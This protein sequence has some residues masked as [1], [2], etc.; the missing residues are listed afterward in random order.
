MNIIVEKTTQGAVEYVA[1]L[2]ANQVKE[3]ESS[4]L[5]LATGRTME[6]VYS[7][8]AQISRK[9]KISFK[10]VSSVNLDEYLG[11]AP[12]NRDSYHHYMKE[13]FFS[14]ID[15]YLENTYLPR[16]NAKNIVEECENYEKI[17][18]NHEGIDL[19]LLGIGANGHIGFNEPGSSFS[20]KTRP[21]VLARETILS[22][23]AMFPSI[24]K[25]PK[26]ALT[27]GIGTILEARKIVLLATG[28]K[29]AKIIA[30]AIEGVMSTSN[31]ASSLQIHPNV[32]VV[33]DEEAASCLERLEYYKWERRNKTW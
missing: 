1:N 10:D 21:K 5:G 18:L 6:R 16:G 28:Y 19:Q 14:K 17:I 23:S 33:L 9:N 4:L 26:V 2:V 11:L 13:H 32:T 12:E 30:S 31:P 15:I 29:K 24:D 3:K 20:S 7:T 8:L 22:N 27:M 25:V